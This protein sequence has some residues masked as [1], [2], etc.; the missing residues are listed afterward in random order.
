MKFVKSVFLSKREKKYVLGFFILMIRIVIW[1]WKIWFFMIIGGF[2]KINKGNRM[3]KFCL[4]K[5]G[6]F[7]YVFSMV[8]IVY[9]V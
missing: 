4:K 9:G 1:K 7:N 6:F 5:L 3:Y 8:I 2:L